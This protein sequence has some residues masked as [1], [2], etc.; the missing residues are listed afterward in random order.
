MAQQAIIKFI[1]GRT[2]WIDPVVNVSDDDDTFAIYNGVHTY[3]YSKVTIKSVEYIE[4]DAKGNPIE[5][6]ESDG[7]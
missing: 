6:K 4:I 1:N 5:P 3:R 7:K 2:D